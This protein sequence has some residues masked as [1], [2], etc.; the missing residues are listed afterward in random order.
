MHLSKSSPDSISPLILAIHLEHPPSKQFLIPEGV[1]LYPVAICLLSF[2]ITA[3]ICLVTQLERS[4]AISDCNIK[5]VSQSGL[6]NFFQIT[7]ISVSILDF[8]QTR[9]IYTATRQSTE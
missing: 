1:P 6:L 3:P 5:Y 9:L 8:V 2:T 7:L 4:F